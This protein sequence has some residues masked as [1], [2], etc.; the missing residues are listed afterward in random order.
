[1]TSSR[2]NNGS[3]LRDDDV[4]ADGESDREGSVN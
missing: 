2:G 3:R 1:M 4:E